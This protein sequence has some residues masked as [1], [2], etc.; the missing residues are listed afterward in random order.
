LGNSRATKPPTQYSSLALNHSL[1]CSF[2][3]ATVYQAHL[4]LGQAY[5]A[6][7]NG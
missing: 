2:P 4:Q 3:S 6:T 1:V 5:L 7:R